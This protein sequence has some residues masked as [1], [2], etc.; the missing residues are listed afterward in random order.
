[1]LRAVGYR[2]CMCGG[3]AV[4]GGTVEGGRGDCLTTTDGCPFVRFAAVGGAGTPLL[5][6]G[7][8]IGK[9]GWLAAPCRVLGF[10]PTLECTPLPFTETGADTKGFDSGGGEGLTGLRSPMSFTMSRMRYL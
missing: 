7:R 1:M 10:I 6:P 2:F 8:I 4:A 9:P 5:V 3:M